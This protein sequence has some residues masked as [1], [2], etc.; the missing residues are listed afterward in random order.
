MRILPNR[1]RYRLKKSIYKNT[2]RG[3]SLKVKKIF[4]P[5]AVFL[6]IQHPGFAQN[7]GDWVLTKSGAL[8]GYNGE[9][10]E[11]VIPAAINGV[12]VR[13]IADAAFRH[14]QLISVVI[15]NSVTH[16]G[17]WAFANNNLTSAL[18]GD[19]VIDIGNY[20]FANNQ[21]ATVVIG[22][23]VKSIG[24]SAFSGNNRLTSLAL[25]DS[26]A[27]IG[28]GA[29]RNNRLASIVIPDSVTSI[30]KNA[31]QDNQLTS[32]TLPRKIQIIP[33]RAFENNQLSSVIIPDKVVSIGPHAFAGN[34]IAS[35]AIPDAVQTLYWDAFMNNREF[36]WASILSPRARKDDGFDYGKVRWGMTEQE[37]EEALQGSGRGK[38]QKLANPADPFMPGGG[39]I[40]PGVLQDYSKWCGEFAIAASYTPVP[41][42]EI[43]EVYAFKQ[44]EGGRFLAGV[45][46]AAA[47]PAEDR[48]IKLL[49]AKYGIL[50]KISGGRYLFPGEGGIRNQKLFD[51]GHTDWIEQ[52][53][54]FYYLPKYVLSTQRVFGVLHQV[55]SQSPGRGAQPRSGNR[56]HRIECM[57][58]PAEDNAAGPINGYARIAIKGAEIPLRDAPGM[59]GRVIGTASG[60]ADSAGV[61]V[62]VPAWEHPQK[63]AIVAEAQPVRDPRDDSLWYRLFFSM[64]DG[65][66]GRIPDSFGKFT[67]EG[68][69]PYVQAKYAELLPFWFEK[70]YIERFNKGQ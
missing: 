49:E 7:A 68:R 28:D 17:E 54:R 1:A 45:G 50:S 59:Q 2:A 41:G 48:L 29:F 35:V 23:R 26:L 66:G 39:M 56:E 46:L 3:G 47:P 36:S 34:Q 25:P 70:E 10:T 15:P 44:K 12:P 33:D 52:G 9:A 57:L 20:A 63:Y 24:K 6:V 62:E 38:I 37:V 19:G 30:G 58:I 14:K 51:A 18:I 53:R 32:L 42:L 21:L 16:I 13:E 67:I 11:L 43:W 27:F 55:Q 8:T 31:F 69:A 61:W 64:H 60:H 40:S 65:Y 4:L 5:L 22:K